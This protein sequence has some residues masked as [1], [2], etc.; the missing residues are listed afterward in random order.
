[1]KNRIKWLSMVLVLAMVALMAQPALAIDEEYTVATIH[2]TQLAGGTN[3][4]LAATT[5][6]YSAVIANCTQ[7][8][9]VGLQISMKG[10]NT[11]SGNVTFEFAKGGDSS[12]FATVAPGA[13]TLTVAGNGST[14]VNYVTN[15]TMGALG[16]LKLTSV[17]NPSASA[18]LTNVTVS[19]IKKPILEGYKK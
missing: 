6:T 11:F 8:D 15:V 5:N 13:F 1:M 7:Y 9:Q 16:Y 4:V 19:V 10:S 14:Q 12:T 2:A 18:Y 17:G 3:N